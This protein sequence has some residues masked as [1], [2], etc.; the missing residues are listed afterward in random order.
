MMQKHFFMANSICQ[1]H[2]KREIKFPFFQ[3]SYSDHFWISSSCGYSQVPYWK[4]N[5]RRRW[6]SADIDIKQQQLLA[7]LFRVLLTFWVFRVHLILTRKV[8]NNRERWNSAD[9]YVK[10]L[11][12][13][14]FLF[15]NLLTFW[16]ILCS[17]NFDQKSKKTER[18][19]QQILNSVNSTKVYFNNQI[20]FIEAQLTEF[21]MIIMFFHV[22]LRIF[23]FSL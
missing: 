12:L 15:R 13:L 23:I 6:K 4:K 17:S 10:Q 20:F 22:I 1:I 9:I 14:A 2:F 7:F 21:G 11:Q 18:W 19:K 8:N 3:K 5:S 16:E